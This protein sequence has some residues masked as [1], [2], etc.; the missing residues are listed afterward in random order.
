MV[1]SGLPHHQP[2]TRVTAVP[3]RWCRVL[4]VTSVRPGYVTGA[5]ASPPTRA[6]VPSEMPS[7][8]SVSE[9]SGT[10]VSY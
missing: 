2:Y 7:V 5:S 3:H 6:L 1:V 4:F 9:E 10:M 8:L